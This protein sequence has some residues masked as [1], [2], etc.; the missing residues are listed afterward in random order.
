MKC[1]CGEE[2]PNFTDF[3]DWKHF[4]VRNFE[5]DC[6]MLPICKHFKFFLPTDEVQ[7]PFL[8]SP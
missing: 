1:P 4:A 2:G 8:M 5:S 7:C 3:T 6:E